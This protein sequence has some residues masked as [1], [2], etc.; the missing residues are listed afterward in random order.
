VKTIAAVIVCFY[1]IGF[2]VFD[3]NYEASILCGILAVLLA[4]WRD[5]PNK[6]KPDEEEYHEPR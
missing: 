5:M 4:I 6:A 2:A 1:A 3:K